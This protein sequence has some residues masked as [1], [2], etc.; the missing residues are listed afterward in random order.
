MKACA[1]SD[2][3]TLVDLLKDV[4][5]GFDPDPIFD[6]VYGWMLEN[7]DKSIDD[8]L[9]WLATYDLQD[10]ISENPADLQLMTIHASKGLEWPIVIIAGL[11]EGIFPSRHALKNEDEMESERRLAYVAYTRA[12]DQLVL[13]SRPIQ[14]DDDGHPRYPVSRFIR[15]GKTLTPAWR[16][17]GKSMAR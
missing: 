3:H 4:E 9:N 8:Y 1:P 11:N 16:Q 5:F 7:I 14:M 6:F 12:E 15:E 10:E 2:I 17:G 13:T